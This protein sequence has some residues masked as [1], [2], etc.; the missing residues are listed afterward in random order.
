MFGC[1]TN[2]ER[3]QKDVENKHF[4]IHYR[5]TFIEIIVV[6]I[7]GHHYIIHANTHKGS[8]IHAEHCPCHNN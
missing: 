8:I 5:D 7:E 3:K 2:K 4:K 1:S 6:E